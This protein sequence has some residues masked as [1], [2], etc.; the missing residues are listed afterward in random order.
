MSSSKSQTLNAS[1]AS[2]GIVTKS[3]AKYSKASGFARL[4][5]YI[6]QDR[7][8]E[9]LPSHRVCNCLKRRIDKDKKRAVVYNESREKA[10]WSNVQRCG[11]IWVCPV[12]AV[13]ITE[14][15][16]NELKTA[17]THWRD[18]L[19]FDVK[20]LTLTFSHSVGHSLRFLLEAQKKALKMFFGHRTFRDISEKLQ[21]HGKIKSLEVTYGKN[22]WHPHNHILLFSQDADDLAY[23]YRDRLAE[24]WIHCCKKAGLQA[25]SMEYG[26]DIRD[27]S[28]ADQYVSKWGLDYEMTKGHVKKGKEGGHTP[29]DLLQ[30]SFEDN[31]IFSNKLPSKLFQEFCIAMKGARQLVWSRGLK[32]FF[33]L[34]D[35]TDEQAAQ[36]MEEDAIFLTDVEDLIFK[37]LIKYKKRHEYLIWCQNDMKNGCWGCGEVEL[38]TNQILQLEIDNL[39]NHEKDFLEYRGLL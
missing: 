38:Y 21:V 13:Q 29:F 20:L 5:A 18:G 1:A 3:H 7:V 31:P 4:H 24:L 28:Y 23:Q 14:V 33:K 37:L 34:E 9:L 25:P 15:R 22:G 19:G 30:M 36:K 39:Q 12:C 35:I 17:V 8:C 2:L 6:L 16:R 27:G 10:H 11:S 26:L 32:M